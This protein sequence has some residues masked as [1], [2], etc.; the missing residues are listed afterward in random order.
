MNKLQT[1]AL[2]HLRGANDFELLVDDLLADLPSLSGSSGQAREG[3]GSNS[4]GASCALAIEGAA[5][6]LDVPLSAAS[7]D[8]TAAFSRGTAIESS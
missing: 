3:I 6:S 2:V 5:F 8:W 7:L 1:S 4:D